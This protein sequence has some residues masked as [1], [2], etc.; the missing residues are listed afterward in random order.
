MMKFRSILC[1]HSPVKDPYVY[2]NLIAH[3]YMRYCEYHTYL[4][5]VENSKMPNSKG[6]ATNSQSQV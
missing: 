3:K 1:Y 2:L 4:Y 5:E 6:C